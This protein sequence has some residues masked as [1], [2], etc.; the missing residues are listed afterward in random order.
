LLDWFRPE[1]F[2]PEEEAMT[3]EDIG[4]PGTASKA[5]SAMRDIMVSSPIVAA[6]RIICLTITAG[7]EE[8][9]EDN[10]AEKN[11]QQVRAPTPE[12]FSFLISDV[13]K[14]TARN[15]IISLVDKGL[16]T[17][18]GKIWYIWGSS[19]QLAINLNPKKE[20]SL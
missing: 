16:L 6:A 3:T 9:D 5:D 19:F 14:K 13:R 17:S 10:L 15:K 11:R 8:A 2:R 1:L 12:P 7:A 20:V 4:V 18:N